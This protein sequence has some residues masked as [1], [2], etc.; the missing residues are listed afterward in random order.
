VTQLAPFNLQFFSGNHVHVC[1][2]SKVLCDETTCTR[3]IAISR[4]GHIILL[5]PRP[6]DGYSMGAYW[7]CSQLA[8][9]SEVARATNSM[10][11]WALPVPPCLDPEAKVRESG[12][13]WDT[14]QARAHAI[15]SWNNREKL[16]ASY[17]KAYKYST[18]Q[19]IISFDFRSINCRHVRWANNFTYYFPCHW[20]N[21]SCDIWSKHVQCTVAHY[22]KKAR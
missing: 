15:F 2:H 17:S 19:K 13:N 4:R 9:T 7:W 12:S 14:G 20:C 3:W 5:S 1:K 8:S 16:R 18:M 6:V 10:L 11:F 22:L 21:V